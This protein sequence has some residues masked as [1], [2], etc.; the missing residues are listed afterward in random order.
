MANRF[1]RSKAV[2][3]LTGIVMVAIGI[4]VLINPIG[5]LEVIVRITGWLLVAYGVIL[6]VPSVMRGNSLQNVSTD[7]VLGVVAALC[8]L[9]MGIAPSFVVS[10]IWTLIGIGILATGVL[11]ILEAG[12]FRRVGSPLGLP[13]TTSGAICVLLGLLVI[14]VPLASPTLGMLVAAVA[15]LIDG[16]TEIIFALGM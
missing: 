6:I 1:T 13:A 12:R 14:F 10:F 3:L 15:L 5:A 16:V 11:D 8:G 7:F 2:I 9:V 4:A